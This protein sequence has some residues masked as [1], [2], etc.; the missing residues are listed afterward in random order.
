MLLHSSP[1]KKQ[2][3]FLFFEE[4]FPEILEILGVYQVFRGRY[5]LLPR[6]L[7]VLYLIFSNFSGGGGDPF[8]SIQLG[9]Y[10]NGRRTWK[11]FFIQRFSISSDKFNLNMTSFVFG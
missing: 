3:R 1:K 10:K 8:F 6:L 9:K 7:I 11:A 2:S 4:W 5:C